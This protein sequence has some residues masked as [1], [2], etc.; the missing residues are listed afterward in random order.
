MKKILTTTVMT[1]IL[2]TSG[3]SAQQGSTEPDDKVGAEIYGVEYFYEGT[4]T[5]GTT[6]MPSGYVS[7]GKTGGNPVIASTWTLEEGAV[8]NVSENGLKLTGTIN[9]NPRESHTI[10]LHCA[11]G[12]SEKFY[13]VYIC[14]NTETY[15]ETI[16]YKLADGTGC[17]V[18]SNGTA[19]IPQPDEADYKLFIYDHPSGL[20][21]LDQFS[22]RNSAQIDVSYDAGAD[23]VQ[24]KICGGIVTYAPSGATILFAESSANLTNTSLKDTE[25]FNRYTLATATSDTAGF[26]E[27]YLGDLPTLKYTIG[28]TT[29]TLDLSSTSGYTEKLSDTSTLEGYLNSFGFYP[30]ITTVL[31][32]TGYDLLATKGSEAAIQISKNTKFSTA[33]SSKIREIK[34]NLHNVGSEAFTEA[35]SFT[36]ANATEGTQDTLVFSGDNSNLVPAMGVTYSDVNVTVCDEDAWIK[37]PKGKSVIFGG[38]SNPTLKMDS[39]MKVSQSLIVKSGS[40][41]DIAKGKTVKFFGTVTLGG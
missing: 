19:V 14:T 24:G 13:Y 41:F 16:Y 9:I 30:N 32:G 15:T 33:A 20:P 36:G 25:S 2:A 27:G 1:A 6:I 5:Y 23:A 12:N 28:E 29:K 37:A 35:L 34:A 4:D 18:D 31:N 11:I 40:K 22:A 7:I 10:P 26:Q 39:D 38:T 8:M 21:V 17:Y 3:F